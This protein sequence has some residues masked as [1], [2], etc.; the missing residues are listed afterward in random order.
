M[1][2][3]HHILRCSSYRKEREQ[4]FA[5][6]TLPEVTE[7]KKVVR[8]LDAAIKERKVGRH[9]KIMWAN[10]NE[11]IMY[12]VYEKYN[13]FNKVLFPFSKLFG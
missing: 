10:F 4:L 9:P 7:E 1:E 6:A 8:I 5:A 13:L 11:H 2:D 3:L 12:Y